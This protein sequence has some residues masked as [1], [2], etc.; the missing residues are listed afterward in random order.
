MRQKDIAAE[1]RGLQGTPLVDK[2]HI[3]VT[4]SRYPNRKMFRH[5]QHLPEAEHEI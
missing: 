1:R 4:E 2:C 5:I 3:P